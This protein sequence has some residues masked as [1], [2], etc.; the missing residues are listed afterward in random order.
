MLALNLPFRFPHLHSLWR[1]ASAEMRSCRRLARTWVFVVIAILFCSGWYFFMN[2]QSLSP[3]PAT[4]W[5]NDLMSPRYTIST[6]MNAFVAIFSFGI[7][8]LTFDIR[9]RDVQNRISDVVDTLPA[10]N[11]EIILGR[12]AGIL[13]LLLIPC[14]IFLGVVAGYELLTYVFGFHYRMGIQPMSVVSLIVWNLIPNLVFFGALVACL[15]TL[16]RLRVLVAVI[17]LALW[18]GSLWAENRIPIE[19]QESLALFLGSTLFPSDLAPVF[20]TP[21]ILGSKLAYLLVSFAFLL[22]AA[23]RVPRT[24][25]RRTLNAIFGVSA[26]GLATALFIGLIL[27]VNGSNNLKQQWVDSHQEQ[28]PSSFPDVQHLDG[29]I[30]LRPGRRISLNVTLTTRMPTE[31]S[32]DSVVFS[33][34]PGYTIQKLSVDGEEV[35]DYNFES[36]LLLVP[37]KLLPDDVHDI[38]V[39]A[40]GKIKEQFAYLDQA[41]DFK[42]IVHH[43]VPRLGLQ[44]SIFHSDFVALMPGS[45][46]YPV[47]G[48]AIDRDML[49]VHPRDVFTTNLKISVP[50][51]WEVATVGKREIVENQ[52]RDTYRFESTVPVPEVALIT[53]RFEHRETTIEGIEFEVLFSKKHRENLDVFAPITDQIVEWVSERI[54]TAKTLSLE[55][56]YGAFYVVEVPSNLRIYGGGWRMDSVLHPP[57]MMLVRETGLPTAQFGSRVDSI[58]ERSSDA[59]SQA[60]ERVFRELLNYFGN[61]EQGGSPFVGFSRNFVSHQLSTSRRGATSLQYLIDQLSNQLI[62][63]L[64]SDSITSSVEF[65]EYVETLSIGQTPDYFA[66]NWAT[67]NRVDISTLPSTWDVLNQTPLIDLDF[68]ASPIPSYRALLTKG[69]PLAKTMIARYGADAMGEFL[70]QLLAGYRSQVLTIEDFV[71]AADDMGLDFYDWVLP[72]LAQTSL[73][74]FIVDAPTVSKLEVPELGVAEYQTTFVLHNTETMPGFVRVVWSFAE[75]GTRLYTWGWGEYN[76]SD[77]VF[78]DGDET[79]RFAIQSANPVTGIWIESFLAINRVPFEMRMADLDENEIQQVSPA[80]PFVTDVEWEPSDTETIIVDDLDPGFSI[81]EMS[82]GVDETESSAIQETHPGQELD[83]GLPLW[84]VVGTWNRR[85]DTGSFG[86]YRQTNTAIVR[87]N[88]NSA[89]RFQTNLPQIGDWKLEIFLPPILFSSYIDPAGTTISISPGAIVISS[90]GELIESGAANLAS[91]NAYYELEVKAGSTSRTV[92]LDIPNAREGWNE[93]GNFEL[94]STDV[95]VL[96]SDKVDHEQLAVF[97]DAIRWTPVDP[98]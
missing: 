62:T 79:K 44:S 31:K 21:A 72:W 37:S 75:E 97:A 76:Y 19:Y 90:E 9:A 55:Y 14:L 93:V 40:R 81:V 65:A 45:F 69:Y 52:K 11:F 10:S 91:E 87:G 25:P 95:V 53:S 50:K 22:F 43:S 67:K 89:A 3:A 28:N 57:G 23:S 54:Q 61:D 8:F 6:M 98:D 15:S 17:A 33:L 51:R 92:E 16:V 77:P 49:E 26:I 70:N 58:Y 82:T 35:T 46:W 63:E 7:I 74:G 4:G 1:I 5:I 27:A 42:K 12:F 66:S 64:E 41:R 84:G 29:T 73:A 30:D 94:N 96:L 86:R 32:T 80:L 38:T 36:G 47:S 13:M 34:N 18:Y 83:A 78:V 24:D 88:G 20:I 56:P 39:E 48:A 85:Y 2:L 60:Q 71:R 68:K 59:N